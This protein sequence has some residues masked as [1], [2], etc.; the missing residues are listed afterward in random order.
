MKRTL[1]LLLNSIKHWLGLQA[2]RRIKDKESLELC[3]MVDKRDSHR[4][5][6]YFRI[7]QHILYR[8]EFFRFYVE[9]M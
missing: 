1:L 8:D 4:P 6:Q 5:Y 7:G 9:E 3:R 2:N